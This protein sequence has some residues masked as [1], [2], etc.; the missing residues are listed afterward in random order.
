MGVLNMAKN[1]KQIHPD[2]VICYKVG[3]FYNSYGK[4]ACIISYLFEYSTR[5]IEEN[6]ISAGFPKSALPKV[7]A[8]LEKEKLNYLI[9]DTKNNYYVDEESDNN[10]LNKYH[11]ISK[12]AQKYVKYKR[13]IDEVKKTLLKN[14]DEE[15]FG[16]KFR[17]IEEML[18]GN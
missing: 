10:N 7:M 14:I 17:K 15:D 6:I 13:R 1:L 3:K 9:L 8:R 16:I 12:K 18:Y 2:F 5:N 4:D 11:E